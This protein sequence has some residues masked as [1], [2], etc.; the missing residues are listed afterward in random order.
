VRQVLG[1]TASAEDYEQIDAEL[2]AQGDDP[3]P[4]GDRPASL[5]AEPPT[6]AEAP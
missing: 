5:A 3:D 2:A 1:D 4:Y 6:D